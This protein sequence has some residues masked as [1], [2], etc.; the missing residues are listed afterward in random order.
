[1]GII[2]SMLFYALSDRADFRKMKGEKITIVKE[3][4]LDGA[5]QTVLVMSAR[6]GERPT[7][8]TAKLPARQ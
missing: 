2:S 8:P 7:K 1:M 3:A 5:G 4:D 6:K